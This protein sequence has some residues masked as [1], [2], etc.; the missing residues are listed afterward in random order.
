MSRWS[1]L[2]SLTLFR[3]WDEALW[4]PQWPWASKTVTYVDLVVTLRWDP[5]GAL[6]ADALW[7][8]G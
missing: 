1:S 2:P 4:W 7:A 6:W 8:D 5:L 3:H